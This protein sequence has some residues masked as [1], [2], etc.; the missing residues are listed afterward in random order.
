MNYC[1][2]SGADQKVTMIG[3]AFAF[4][5][6]KVQT[7]I[8]EIICADVQTTGDQSTHIHCGVF[9]KKDAV[10]VNQYHVAIGINATVNFRTVVAEDT[11]EGD[12]RWTMS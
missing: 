9:T 5:G 7:T 12:G 10:R 2:T 8:H 4:E 11:V 1:A 6:R 3:G